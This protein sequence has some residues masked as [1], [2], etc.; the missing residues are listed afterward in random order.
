MPSFC[1]N[2]RDAFGLAAGRKGLNFAVA[3]PQKL[4][5]LNAAGEMESSAVMAPVYVS[6]QGC[7]S[8]HMENS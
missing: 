1:V 2:A 8:R 7:M 6:L 4:L 5:L 3:H